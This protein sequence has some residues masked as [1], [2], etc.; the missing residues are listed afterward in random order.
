MILGPSP[1]L[2]GPTLLLRYLLAGLDQEGLF[3][4]GTSS[5]RLEPSGLSRERGESIR[6]GGGE[7]SLEGGSGELPREYFENLC[8]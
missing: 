3:T 2:D 4:G 7:G 5:Q 8:L 1:N 6:G